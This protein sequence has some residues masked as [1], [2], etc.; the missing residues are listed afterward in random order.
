MTAPCQLS[1]TDI[2]HIWSPFLHLQPENMPFC[3]DRDPL[4][5]TQSNVAMNWTETDLQSLFSNL[6]LS[7]FS[8]FQVVFFNKVF[9]WTSYIYQFYFC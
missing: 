7:F 4:F 9:P 1:A 2:L 6:F 8:D 3:G 5:L